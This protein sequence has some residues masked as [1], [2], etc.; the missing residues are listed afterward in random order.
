MGGWV[1]PNRVCHVLHNLFYLILWSLL[2]FVHF[3]R[4][5]MSGSRRMTSMTARSAFI[6]VARNFGHREG[7]NIAIIMKELT[8]QHQTEK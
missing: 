5:A 1:K 4:F 6:S 8:L 7:K 3:N 2:V